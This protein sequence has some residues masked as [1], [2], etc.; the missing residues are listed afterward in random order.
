M[1]IYTPAYHYQNARRELY[2]MVLN[3]FIDDDSFCIQVDLLSAL[4]RF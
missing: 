1:S 2:L 3:G 4:S